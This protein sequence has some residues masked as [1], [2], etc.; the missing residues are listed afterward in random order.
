M[1]A[2]YTLLIVVLD[3]KYIFNIYPVLVYLHASFQLYF[4][5]QTITPFI[6]HAIKTF[7]HICTITRYHE[8]LDYKLFQS[9]KS[10]SP[11]YFND[12]SF[13][14]QNLFFS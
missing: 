3:K 9:Y 11:S 13:T 5:F 4:V 14:F 12:V 6:T 8:I 1:Y 7:A 2:I 10:V